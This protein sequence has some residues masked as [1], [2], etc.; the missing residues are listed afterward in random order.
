MGRGKKRR[1]KRVE[2]RADMQRRDKGEGRSDIKEGRK[3][4]G[5]EKMGKGKRGR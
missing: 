1:V 3:E 2:E 5:E 4:T